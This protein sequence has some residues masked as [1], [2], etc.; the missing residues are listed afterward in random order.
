MISPLVNMYVLCKAKRL[1]LALPEDWRNTLLRETEYCKVNRIKVIYS[2]IWDCG[3]TVPNASATI[4][5]VILVNAEWAALIAL[6]PDREDIHDAFRLT[7]GHE[8]THHEKDY[9]FIEPFSKASKF[10]YWVNEVHADFGGIVKVFDANAEQGMSAM[11][12]KK[13]C[14]GDRDK[15]G[16]SH[17]SWKRRIEFIG[18]Y[19]FNRELILKIAHITGCKNKELIQRVCE[20]FEEINLRR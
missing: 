6:Y 2:W 4:P 20:H 8:M 7:M 13:A 11:Q 18:N 10:V 14:K 15:D 19:D 5:G 3:C 16:H 9:F 17:P 12:F 1:H